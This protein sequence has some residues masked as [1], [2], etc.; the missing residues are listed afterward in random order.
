MMLTIGICDDEITQLNYL[1]EKIAVWGNMTGIFTSM[2]EFSSAESFWFEWIEDKSCDLLLLDVQMKQMDGMELAKKIRTVDKSIP[3]IFI[4]GFTDYMAQGYE[5][6]AFHYLLK[7]VTQEKLNEVLWDIQSCKDES[8]AYLKA[9]EQYPGIGS[10]LDQ[11]YAAQD[12]HFTLFALESA[13]DF[14]ARRKPQI[15]LRIKTGGLHF[16][17]RELQQIFAWDEKIQTPFQNEMADPWRNF[18][19]SFQFAVLVNLLTAMIYG[20][21]L[22]SYEKSV[23]MHI[24]AGTMGRRTVGRMMAQKVKALAVLTGVQYLASMAVLCGIYFGSC[25]PIAWNSQVQTLYFTSILPLCYRDVFVLGLVSGMAA[26]WAAA[27]F[28][29]FLDAWLQKP[30]PALAIGAAVMFVPLVLRNFTMLPNSVMKLVQVFPVH[31]ALLKETVNSL[32]LYPFPGNGIPG[33]YVLPVVCALLAAGLVWIAVRLAQTG[34]WKE[35]DG[36]GRRRREMV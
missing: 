4:T 17:K 22:F 25:A 20:A 13:D 31:T 9:V 12:G 23:R 14:Y 35:G 18:Y 30:V 36:T 32:Y 21:S 15:K 26:V 29:A 34:I 10:L 33:I 7:P 16:S 24:I 19:T 27:F 6:H 1:K 8:A 3:I 5:V 2:R 28:A 11:A